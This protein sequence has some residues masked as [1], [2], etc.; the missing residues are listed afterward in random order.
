M[1]LM[2]RR[3]IRTP[4]SEQYALF[5]LDRRDANHDPLS[6]GKV[7]LHYTSDGT[8]GTFLLWNEAIVDLP[9]DQVHALVETTVHELCDPVGIPAFHVI[10]YFSP[11]LRSRLLHCSE[12]EN[13]VTI[14]LA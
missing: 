7:D 5:D 8:F 4:S 12:V 10:E 2:L 6:V 13:Q 1:K 14:E 3:L 9:S 11:D